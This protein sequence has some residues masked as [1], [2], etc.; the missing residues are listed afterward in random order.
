MRSRD[1]VRA[2]NLIADSTASRWRCVGYR[3]VARSGDLD[4]AIVDYAE[5]NPR[6]SEI[7][8]RVHAPLGGVLAK[9]PG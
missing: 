6:R 2:I 9:A 4:R 7:G 3:C 5:I 1:L 8:R